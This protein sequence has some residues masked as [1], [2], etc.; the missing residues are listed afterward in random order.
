MANK[1][2]FLFF[3]E[4]LL[5]KTNGMITMLVLLMRLSVK[6][7]DLLLVEKLNC[8]KKIDECQIYLLIVI[9]TNLFLIYVMV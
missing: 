3:H 8:S 9:L 4:N 7:S 5:L 2:I 6:S 1:I